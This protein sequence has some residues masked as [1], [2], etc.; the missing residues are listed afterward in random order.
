MLPINTIYKRILY[1][2]LFTGILT[3][4]THAQTTRTETPIPAPVTPHSPIADNTLSNAGL[5]GQEEQS[6]WMTDLNNAV[7]KSENLY[8][9]GRLS[10]YLSGYAHHGRGT[11]TPDKIAELN[12][13]VWGFGVS[14]EM[15]DEKDN[16]ESILFVIM[17]DS[18][19][20]PQLTAGYKYE[21]M[22][23]LG[24]DYE[25][26]VGYVAGVISRVDIFGGIPFPGILPVASIGT[27]DTK[28]EFSYIP[29]LT[30]NKG[31]GDILF[32]S[33]RLNLK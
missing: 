26:G 32:I 13:K 18:H 19:Y 5:P 4:T 27:H 30:K 31:N 14:K 8:N 10:M 6:W 2:L 29:R 33:L 15:R 1:A 24:N 11:Y 9:N 17:A 7:S 21:W 28:L 23:P 12:E 20:E 22:K 25:A 16:E 3:A